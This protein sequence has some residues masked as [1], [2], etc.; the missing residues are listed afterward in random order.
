MRLFVRTQN[1]VGPPLTLEAFDTGNQKVVRL[2]KQVKVSGTQAWTQIDAAFNS[3]SSTNLSLYFGVWG[4]HQGTLWLDDVNLEET[5]LVFLIRRAGAP[6]RVYDPATGKAFNEGSDFD[7]LQDAR[8]TSDPQSDWHE[9]PRITLPAGSTLRPGQTVAVDF[10]AAQPVDSQRLGV[11]LT[12]PAVTTWLDANARKILDVIRPDTGIFLQYDEMRQVNSCKSCRDL[13]KTAGQLLAWHVG[14]AIRRYRSLRPDEAFWVWSDMFDPYANAH[15]NYYLGEGD[16][17]GSWEGLSSEVTIMN[18]NMAHLRDSLRW[19]A[20]ESRR[21]PTPHR[22]IIAGY[23]DTRNG[24][25]A[26]VEELRTARGIPGIDGLMYTTWEDDYSQMQSFATAARKNW[27]AYR[28]SV[29]R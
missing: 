2:Y 10:Y 9:P 1:Y 19:F 6:V 11:C 15:S 7:Q 29:L 13:H 5:A 4:G 18:W 22:Q 14:Q 16:L 25:G 23:Y 21:Q 12:D 17:A 26:A 27:Q 8:L 28:D 3:Q 20:G 24:A